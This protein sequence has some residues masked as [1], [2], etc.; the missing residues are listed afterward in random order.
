MELRP[1]DDVGVILPLI[2][3][4]GA[5]R[6]HSEADPFRSGE[7]A[8]FG[9]VDRKNEQVDHGERRAGSEERDA[10]LLPLSQHG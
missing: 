10:T 2:A 3:N 9:V 5:Q 8:R 4:Q 7:F 1:S 6:G